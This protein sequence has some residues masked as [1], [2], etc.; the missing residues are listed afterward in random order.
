MCLRVY[1]STE[2]TPE[3]RFS[4]LPCLSSLNLNAINCSTCLP[5][6]NLDQYVARTSLSINQQLE[7]GSFVEISYDS[8]RTAVR[9]R[10][11]MAYNGLDM[12]GECEE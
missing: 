8:Y 9:Y 7:R 4:Q 10:R 12:L 3:C 11:V 1:L 6:C 2:N 5:S